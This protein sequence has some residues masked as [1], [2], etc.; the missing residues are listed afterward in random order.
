MKKDIYCI[1][2][3]D[4][5]RST[6]SMRLVAVCT[7]LKHVKRIISDGIKREVFVFD[8]DENVSFVKQAANFRRAW[9]EA[10]ED[11]ADTAIDVIDRLKYGHIIAMTPNENPFANA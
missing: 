8:S 3:C 7:N 11:G 4:E 10:I 9:D 5:W 1:F 6:N 2:T